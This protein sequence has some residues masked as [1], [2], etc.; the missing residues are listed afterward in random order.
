MNRLVLGL[1]FAITVLLGGIAYELHTLNDRLDAFA[2]ANYGWPR[3]AAAK[4]DPTAKPQTDEERRR[5][6]R[7]DVK[8]MSEDLK[9][10]LRP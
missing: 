1:A 2:A 4:Y 8:R 3:L 10:V 7:E 6:L 5:E 9:A